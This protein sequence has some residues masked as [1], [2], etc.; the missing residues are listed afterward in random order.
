MT[1]S[2]APVLS[3]LLAAPFLF[4]SLACE[5]EDLGPAPVDSTPTPSELSSDWVVPDRY[6]AE[7]E[8]V[9]EL[10]ESGAWRDRWSVVERLVEDGEIDG[11]PILLRLLR[12]DDTP[13][14]RIESARALCHLGTVD[15]G[16]ALIDALGDDD[17][18]VRAVAAQALAE[19]RDPRGI[20]AIEPLLEDEFDEVREYARVALVRLGSRSVVDGLRR[21]LRASSAL[22]RAAACQVLAEA[23]SLAAAPELVSLLSDRAAVGFSQVGPARG[24]SPG[25]D[26]A[27][28]RVSDHA[29]LALIEIAGEVV[30]FTWNATEDR[31]E[32]IESQWKSWLRDNTEEVQQAKEDLR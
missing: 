25:D 32:E 13:N 6:A 4:V 23:G 11:V 26:L 8:A 28:E 17:E 10:L 31:R 14:V 16:P 2:R 20:A 12:E 24:G 30:P 19:L 3:T 18:G 1:S 15:E 27:E 21:Q 29:H 7:A 5:E 9:V 22:D